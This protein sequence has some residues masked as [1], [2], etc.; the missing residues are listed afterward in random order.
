MSSE[1]R[2]AAKSIPPMTD[3]LRLKVS[4]LPE[5]PGVYRYLNADGA[6]IYVGKAK[7]LRRRVGSYFNRDHAVLRTAVLVRHIADLQY[8]VVD[9]E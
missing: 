5:S 9:T 7:N 6:V 4:L 3:E 2:L 1:V 8:T